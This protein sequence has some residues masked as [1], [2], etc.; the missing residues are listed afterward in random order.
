M[1]YVEDHELLLGWH[2][3]MKFPCAK[4]AIKAKVVQQLM[5]LQIQP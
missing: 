5:G 3:F 4:N 2:I 1:Q